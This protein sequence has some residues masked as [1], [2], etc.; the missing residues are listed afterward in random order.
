MKLKISP[1][2]HSFTLT[3]M[4]I[5][6]AIASTILAVTLTSSVALQRSY[7]EVDN[8]STTHMQQIR[9]VD[10]LARDVRRGLSVTS[11]IDLQTVTIT[12][13]KYI[14]QAGDSEAIANPSLIGT[15]RPPKRLYVAGSSDANINYAATTSTVVYCISNSQGTDCNVSGNPPGQ[16]ILRKQDGVVT[17][18][19][20]S[21]DNLLP[22]TTD[23]ELANTEYTT[24]AVTFKP[25]SVADRSG[26]IVYSTAYLRNRRRPPPP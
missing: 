10:Y 4:M 18:I 21:T 3:E 19:A 14:I 5:A 12:V 7:N 25:T 1:K 15:P 8:Y 6:M 9:I 23:I 17:T 2:T 26:T 22:A 16:A 11:S 20:S 24:T 13:P